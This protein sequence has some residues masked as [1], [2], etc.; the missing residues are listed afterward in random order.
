ML[1]LVFNAVNNTL[2]SCHAFNATQ[3]QFDEKR[4]SLTQSREDEKDSR[5]AEL[6]THK[7]FLHRHYLLWCSMRCR[8]TSTLTR[9]LHLRHYICDA[10]RVPSYKV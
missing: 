9:D 2:T 4:D 1:H 6:V 8:L 3:A 5:S 7:C 10:L